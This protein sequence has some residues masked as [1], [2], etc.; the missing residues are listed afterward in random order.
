MQRHRP[1]RRRFLRVTGAGCVAGL[2]G[3]SQL[4][5]GGES[6]ITDT[7]GDGV[8]DSE[9]Y[10]PGDPNVQRKEQLVRTETTTAET[11]T[12]EPTTTTPTT[13]TPPI[14][15]VLRKS[16]PDPEEYVGDGPR[17][18][19]DRAIGE[20]RIDTTNGSLTLVGPGQYVI[21]AIAGYLAADDLR[22]TDSW[23]HVVENDTKLIGTNATFKS[24]TVRFAA[25]TFEGVAL[26]AVRAVD[27]YVDDE[28]VVDRVNLVRY[29]HGGGAFEWSKV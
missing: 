6:G 22:K 11:A 19:Y 3:C 21:T 4:S 1:S 20:V 15:P 28:R 24:D 7:D 27:L 26:R 13:T 23:D 12:V 29:V 9:D 17:A 14:P 18:D 2:A 5:G 8:I 10:A 16:L 25:D